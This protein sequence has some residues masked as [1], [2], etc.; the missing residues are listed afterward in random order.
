[1]HYV[2]KSRK[3]NLSSLAPTCTWWHFAR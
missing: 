1:M 3:M 2:S